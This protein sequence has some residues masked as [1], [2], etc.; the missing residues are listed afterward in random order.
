M[1]P[2]SDRRR[3]PG[4]SRRS[5]RLPLGDDGTVPGY[6]SGQRTRAGHL[7]KTTAG[8]SL[9]APLAEVF[10]RRHRHGE[11]ERVLGLAEV[12]RLV[13]FGLGVLERIL[14]RLLAQVGQIELSVNS[15]P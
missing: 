10:L 3:E 7:T 8:A 1:G 9:D 5:F 11:G 14:E 2:R 15:L 4:S 13:G 6:V 12:D